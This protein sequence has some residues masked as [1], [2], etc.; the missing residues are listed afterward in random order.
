MKGACHDTASPPYDR[1][2]DP[3]QSRAGTI[4]QY[5]NCVAGLTGTSTPLR[6]PRAQQVRSYLLHLVQEHHVSWSYYCQVRSALQFLYRVT[7]GMDWVV[8]EVACP[9][10]PKRLPVILSPDELV[11]FFKAA[12]N[13]KH[14]VILMTTYA[15]GLRLSEVCRLQVEDI[16]SR[17]GHPH[18]SVQGAQGSRRH[19]LPSAPDNPPPVL[20]DPATQ[21]LSLPR[22]QARPADQSADGREG[23]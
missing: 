23:L 21:A 19:A 9:K 2:H 20:E 10:V 1:G 7:L 5:V 3:P 13:L 14:R 18:S 12:N 6:A 15:A 22:M 17:R 16:D 4:R 8:E 11:R